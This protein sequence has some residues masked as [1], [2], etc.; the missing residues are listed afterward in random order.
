MPTSAQKRAKKLEAVVPIAAPPELKIP[1]KYRTLNNHFLV[2]RLDMDD[3]K[4]ES[5]R[6]IKPEIARQ[7]SQR[8]EVRWAPKGETECPVGTIVIFTK[9]GGSDVEING[10]K[11]S[12]VQRLQ[13][14]AIEEDLESNAELAIGTGVRH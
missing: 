1:K 8:G 10:E 14:Y 7:R 6:L 4:T 9:Y 12:L 11:L 5:G 3:E 2:K 13:L